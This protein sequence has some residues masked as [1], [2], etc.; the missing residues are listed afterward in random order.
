M[1][2]T[3]DFVANYIEDK[4]E[5]PH[6]FI[7]EGCC[8]RCLRGTPVKYNLKNTSFK[9]LME[10]G[11]MEPYQAASSFHDSKFHAASFTN[12]VINVNSDPKPC[13]YPRNCEVK[14]I[15]CTTLVENDEG[16]EIDTWPGFTVH[17]KCLGICTTPC[18][19]KLLPVL[20]VYMSPQRA[21]LKCER[22]QDKKESKQPPPK[23]LKKANP[24]PTQPIYQAPKPTRLPEPLPEPRIVPADP[25]IKRTFSFKKPPSAKASKFDE[26]GKSKCIL[27][28]F[29]APITEQEQIK[30]AV[31]KV[32]QDDPTRRFLKNSKTG[33]IFGER[34][35]GVAYHLV[36]GERLFTSDTPPCNV[37]YDFTPP[38]TLTS[39]LEQE[40]Q[41]GN[42]R[43]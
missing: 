38:K 10:N 4:Y 5:I 11:T 41:E 9:E 2:S 3:T 31:A 13:K 32:K 21:N 39:S 14:C 19:R 6:V 8:K 43:P 20:P 23:P 24:S 29:H 34:R 12:D 33:E 40:Q 16:T 30:Q 7:T 22:H 42:P 25:P 18:C 37:K 35:G 27:A 17:K 15:I 28:F 1:P 36:T 26:R